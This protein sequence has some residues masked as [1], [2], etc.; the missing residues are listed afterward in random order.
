ME[1]SQDI[2]DYIYYDILEEGERTIFKLLN[3]YWNSKVKGKVNIDALI[4]NNN[5][6]TLKYLL[7]DTQ[8][9]SYGLML[10]AC[11]SGKLEIIRWIYDNYEQKSHS[12]ELT[13]R[14]CGHL[15]TTVTNTRKDLLDYWTFC[16][17]VRSGN[18]EAIDWILHTNNIKPNDED[19][20]MHVAMD[21]AVRTGSLE[22]IK[23]LRERGFHWNEET[24]GVAVNMGRM[25]VIKYL[26]NPNEIQGIVRDT[27]SGCPWDSTSVRESAHMGNVELLEWLLKNGCPSCNGVLGIFVQNGNLE[28]AKRVYEIVGNLGECES[29]NNCDGGLM[30]AAA[31]SGNLDMCKW[32]YNDVLDE[33]RRDK[34]KSTEVFYYAAKSHK[35][36]N[37]EVMTWLK[38]HNFPTDGSEFST[39]L[40]F[41][42][43][44]NA[45]WLFDGWNGE[46]F[47]GI[48]LISLVHIKNLYKY[49]TTKNNVSPP[50]LNDLLILAVGRE[51]ME[52]L[53]WCLNPKELPNVEV[54]TVNGA[55]LTSELLYSS[56]SRDINISKLLLSLGCPGRQETR[57][58]SLALKSNDLSK[59]KWMLNPNDIPG[60]GRD[61]VNAFGWSETTF[62]EA[63][64]KNNL[65]LLKLLANPNNIPD[66]GRDPINGC[67]WNDRVLQPAILYK[68]WDI[69]KWLCNPNGIQGVGRD[70]INGCPLGQ[71]VIMQA[72]HDDNLEVI[73]WLCN[74]NDIDVG[75]IDQ[76][77]GCP[78]GWNC[79]HFMI[80][81]ERMTILNWFSG[82]L[83]K[84]NV[85]AMSAAARENK[86]KLMKELWSSGYALDVTVFNMAVRFGT[87]EML[88]WLANPREK[89]DVVFDVE[90]ACPM[91]N[92]I[93]SHAVTG[94]KPE[95]VKW[96][97]DNVVDINLELPN[98]DINAV[99]PEI[100]KL[101][102]Q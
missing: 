57:M 25:D 52:L 9:N 47:Y 67:P 101:L 23:V 77:N 42:N 87:V 11:L 88:N 64:W 6:G 43:T 53:K 59:I 65:D 75:P 7:M 60:V 44:E 48:D 28:K 12:D 102:E 15:V 93:L 13:F 8:Y 94:N 56:L 69:I 41:D 31:W 97:L 18:M 20:E 30:K 29:C 71:S 16:S 91:D 66:V 45:M 73:K 78:Y 32:I 14:L 37:I 5:L 54:D 24:F 27:I 4:K 83:G 68:N 51:D 33:H 96:I 34:C 38:H 49:Y 98:V 61:P 100:L 86:L 26:S 17:T 1:L 84:Q 39:A 35:D 2:V 46:C 10:K 40:S 99:D 22:I 92:N 85:P 36:N 19:Q 3:T 55:K 95:N 89:V 76:V 80:K 21:C 74:P 62:F 63:V 90:Y 81:Y 72:I 79:F 70:N 58:L 82:I 50:F